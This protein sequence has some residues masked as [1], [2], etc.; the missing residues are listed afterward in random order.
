MLEVGEID[1]L[2]AL[3]V[4]PLVLAEEEQRESPD[5][6]EVRRLAWLKSLT[7]DHSAIRRDEQNSPARRHSPKQLANM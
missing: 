5:S 6:Y 4:A 7:V 3:V 1:F 2:D